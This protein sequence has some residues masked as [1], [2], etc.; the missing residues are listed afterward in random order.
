MY[1]QDFETRSEAINDIMG[2]TEL[3]YNEERSAKDCFAA[4]QDKSYDRSGAKIE[5]GLGYLLPRKI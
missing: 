3:Y 5:K 1:Y 2:Y 4:T